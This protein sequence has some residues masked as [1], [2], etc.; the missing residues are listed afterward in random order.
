MRTRCFTP[1]PHRWVVERTMAW[2]MPHRRLARDY[3]TLPASSTV[4]HITIITRDQTETAESNV[5]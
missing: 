2:L 4:I 3:E 5:R 1:L